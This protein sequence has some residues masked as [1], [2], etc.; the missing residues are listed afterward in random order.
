[1]STTLDMTL[2]GVRQSYASGMTPAELM[3]ILRQRAAS[4]SEHNMFIHLLSADEL[5]PWIDA[6]QDKDPASSPLCWV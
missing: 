6:L 5:Q 4:L 1:M 3:A 2:A